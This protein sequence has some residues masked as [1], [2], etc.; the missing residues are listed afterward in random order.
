[1]SVDLSTY[2]P[3][4]P[5]GVGPLDEASRAAARDYYER[6]MAAREE[7]KAALAALAAQSGLDLDGTGDSVVPLNDWFRDNVGPRPDGED[8]D[9][10]WLGIAVDSHVYLGDVLIARHPNLRWAFE[11]SSRRHLYYQH[12]VITGFRTPGITGTSAN[13]EESLVLWARELVFEPE[14][15]PDELAA[16]FARWDARA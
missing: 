1:M 4:D 2:L 12:S 14:A 15:R 11:T 9:P 6:L 3:F 10:M 13:F 7:R 16:A 5:R 8:V